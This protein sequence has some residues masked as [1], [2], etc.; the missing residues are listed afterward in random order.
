MTADLKPAAVFCVGVIGM[1]ACLLGCDRYVPVNWIRDER[2]GKVVEV[3]WFADGISTEYSRV[4]FIYSAPPG[5]SGR[6]MVQG[7]VIEISRDIPDR[8]DIKLTFKDGCY[9]LQ[10]PYGVA[11]VMVA[12][13]LDKETGYIMCFRTSTRCE[14]DDY[15][16][17]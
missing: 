10:A 3:D 1:S 14:D 13:F 2:T 4:I 5:I 15:V 17:C 8:K 6:R 7:H 16:Y 11:E 12:E 9:L